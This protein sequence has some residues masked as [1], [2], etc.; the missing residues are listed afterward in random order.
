VSKIGKVGS[1]LK[2]AA[3]YIPRKIAARYRA[4]RAHQWAPMMKPYLSKIARIDMINAELDRLNLK[5]NIIIADAEHI[6]NEAIGPFR[7]TV[8]I[9]PNWPTHDQ[10]LYFGEPILGFP[11]KPRSIKE[12][13]KRARK[14]IKKNWAMGPS[15]WRAAIK[16]GLINWTRKK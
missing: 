9:K 16:E 7:L 4:H 13:L 2:R 8:P 15:T 6:E 14:A 10:K 1:A 11:K 5:T 3:L 12:L